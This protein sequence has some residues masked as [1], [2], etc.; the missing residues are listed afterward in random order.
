ME[1]LREEIAKKQVQISTVQ[2]EYRNLL[3]QRTEIAIIGP[4]ALQ[5]SPPPRSA[6]ADQQQ[7]LNRLENEMAEI[8][9]MLNDYGLKSKNMNANRL[10]DLLRDVEADESHNAGA[11]FASGKSNPFGSPEKLIGEQNE[12]Q[13][14]E[15]VQR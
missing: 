10:S 12:N 15:F 11:S 9:T 13:I 6:A 1:F 7:N 2:R 14:E 5:S 3:E 8:R 4:N